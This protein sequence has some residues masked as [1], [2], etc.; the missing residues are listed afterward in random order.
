L[1]LHNRKLAGIFF[2]RADL[3]VNGR[4]LHLLKGGSLNNF[5]GLGFVVFGI[6]HSSLLVLGFLFG[7][8]LTILSIDSCANLEGSLTPASQLLIVRWDTRSNSAQS[9]CLSPLFL[10]ASV[11]SSL[12]VFMSF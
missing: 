10:R 4:A 6:T 2:C 1:G 8:N 3:D 7:N 12:K 9:S 11:S 5:K